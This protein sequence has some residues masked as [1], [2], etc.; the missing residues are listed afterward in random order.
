[1]NPTIETRYALVRYIV[2][3]YIA[4]AVWAA[5]F[6][7]LSGYGIAVA[8]L[9]G[10][11]FGAVSGFF[12]VQLWNVLKYGAG[13]IRIP[14]LRA[15]VR[16][17]VGTMFTAVSVGA[18]TVAVWMATGALSAEFATTIPARCL[19]VA[20]VYVCFVLWYLSVG[21]GSDARDGDNDDADDV[22]VAGAA[23]QGGGSAAESDGAAATSGGGVK[24]VVGG[25][26]EDLG[27]A[28]TSAGAANE[29]EDAAQAFPIDRVTVRGAGGR[30]EVIAT[31]EIVCIRAEGDYVAIVTARGR[32]LKEGT[33][34]WFE[35]ALPRARFVRV[36]RS[37]IVSVGHISR[38]ETS[39]RDHTLTLRD[40]AGTI[41]ISDT[42]YR[43]LKQRLGF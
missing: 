14:I 7:P 39:G 41:R 13:Q 26:I 38:I 17:V 25:A 40:G 1:V 28:A 8:A 22:P 24:E 2:L 12:G 16:V 31:D 29:T 36:H 10:A 19:T 20:V 27:G 15:A 11:V 34:K 30:I 42:Y 18:Q 35:Q 37:C 4:A 43:L 33:M 3:W 9:D 5:A 23:I 32:W 21:V 6:G